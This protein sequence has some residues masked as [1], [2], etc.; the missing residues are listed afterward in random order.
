MHPVSSAEA[1]HHNGHD[2]FSF[3]IWM[4]LRLRYYLVRSVQRIPSDDKQSQPVQCPRLVNT[5]NVLV[6]LTWSDAEGRSSNSCLDLHRLFQGV[7]LYPF[8]HGC[9]R[10]GDRDGL[11]YDG[12][13]CT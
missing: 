8:H 10:V 1:V 11:C 13:P 2:V 6:H 12:R 4:K 9:D 5:K 3:L 7:R